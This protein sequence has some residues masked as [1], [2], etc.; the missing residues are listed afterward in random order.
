MKSNFPEISIK[1]VGTLKWSIM[2]PYW[3]P[4]WDQIRVKTRQNRAKT[5]L[6]R[7]QNRVQRVQNSVPGYKRAF[8]KSGYGVGRVPGWWCTPVPGT[9]CPVPPPRVPDL[10]HWPVLAHC[11]VLHAWLT[12]IGGVHQA[13]FR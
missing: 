8:M 6:K 12:G 1:P 2:G 9:R 10:P 3:D 5:W 13:S 11:P 4:V 7:V